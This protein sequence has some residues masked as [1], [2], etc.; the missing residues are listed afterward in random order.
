MA[1]GTAGFVIRLWSRTPTEDAHVIGLVSIVTPSLNQG[2]FLPH[3]VESVLVQ[4]GVDVEYFVADGGS[5]DETLDVLRRY[6]GRLRWDSRPDRGQSHAVN[7]GIR[8][9]SGPVVGW[10]NA[11][12]VYEPGALLA[13]A[14]A[15]DADPELDVVYGRANWIDASGA[16]LGPY[17]T[18]PW[19]PRRLVETCFLCQPA[20]FMRRRVFERFGLLDESLQYCMDY[21]YWLRLA[22]GGARFTHI[23]QVLAGSRLHPEAKTLR[24][25]RAVHREICRMFRNRLGR[26]PGAWLLGYGKAA[27]GEPGPGPRRRAAYAARAVA[28]SLVAAMRWN[29][30]PD[31]EWASAVHAW[32]RKHAGLPRRSSRRD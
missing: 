19:D 4:E 13:A 29:G 8:A 24:D 25:R 16:V 32:L 22:R 26:V 7:R 1:G 10:L 6:E 23:R 9:T 31:G 30:G 3:A 21:E 17:P 12:D 14:E 18:E 5:S 27:A 28:G 15:L 2:R 20:V 11:D